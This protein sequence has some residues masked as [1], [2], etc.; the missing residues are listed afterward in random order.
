MPFN[1]DFG[2]LNL[3]MVHRYTRE[4]ARLLQVSFPQNSL[5]DQNL[6]HVC[7]FIIGRLIQELS[8]LP[9]LLKQAR[10]AG[11]RRFPHGRFHDH[12]IEAEPSGGLR[13]LQDVS[14]LLRAF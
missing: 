11:Q 6:N 3:A 2:P 1:Q 12:C 7:F 9:L 14:K 4:L 13:A 10:Q 8:H 5:E